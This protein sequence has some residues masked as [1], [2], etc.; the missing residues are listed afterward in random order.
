MRDDRLVLWR[1]LLHHVRHPVGGSR[2][3]QTTSHPMRAEL[4]STEQLRDHFRGLAGWH[5]LEDRSWR[6]DPLLRRLDDNAEVLGDA[7]RMLAEAASAK[8]RLAPA[9][10]WLLDNNYLI[11]E[12]VRTARRHLPRS[13][14]RLLPKLGNGPLAG[15]ARTYSL[16]YELILHVDARVD[17]ASLRESIAAYQE[18]APLR[19]GEL[20]SVPIMLRL[21]LIENLRRVAMRVSRG[22][23][24]T[25]LALEWSRRLVELAEHRPT[26]LVVGLADLSRSMS[27]LPT[28][29]VT[30]LSRRIR[31]SHHGMGLV[32][33]WLEQRLGEHGASIE[34]LESAENRAQ[35]ADRV[36]VGNSISSMRTLGAMDWRE[37]VEQMSVAERCLRQDPAGVYPGCAFQTRDQ[38]RHVVESVSRRSKLSEEEVASLAVGLAGRAPPGHLDGRSRHVGWWLIGEGRPELEAA[39]QARRGV[40]RRLADAAYHA[41]LPLYLL[42]VVAPS[43]AGWWWSAERLG[44]AGLAQPWTWLLALA[45]ALVVSQLAIT[46]LNWWC[47]IALRPQP[48]PRLELKEGLPASCRT[49]VL[50]PCQLSDAETIDRLLDGLEVRWVGNREA[51]TAMLLLTDFE[52]AQEERLPGDQA[53]VDRVAQGIDALNARWGNPSQPRPFGLLHR[54][55]VRCP[56]EGRWMGWERKRGKI[57]QFL[58]AL[59]DPWQQG[60]PRGFS[61]V[62]AD[63]AWLREVV[64]CLV[65]DADTRLPMESV[66]SLAA[67]MHHPL[68]RPLVGPTRVVERGHGLLQPRVG[69]T[70]TS[71]RSS[72]YAMMQAVEPGLD[73]YTRTVSDIYQDLFDEG[74]FVGKGIFEVSTFLTT[75]EGRMPE[76]RIL[77]HDLLEGSYVRAGLI[78]DIELFE[79]TPSA[80]LGD[81]SRRHRWVRGDW[82]AAAWL[83]RRVPGET[84]RERNPLHLLAQWKLLDN[85]RR[86]LVPAA[87]VAA[88]VLGWCLGRSDCLLLVAA[89]W[90]VPSA[91]MLIRSL[92]RRPEAMPLDQHLRFWL[93]SLLR[94]A[95]QI[96][97]AAV[98]ALH[99]AVFQLDAILR[100][101]WR[102]LRRRRL[103]EWKTAAAAERESLGLAGTV[104][105][106]APTLL[107][108]LLLVLLLELARPSAL[109]PA[110]PL[111][112]LWLASPVL[113]WWLARPPER[114]SSMQV[115]EADR[116]WLR[117][118]ARRTWRWF[119][120]F[121]CEEHNFLAP[122]NFQEHPVAVVA[123]R[124]SPTNIGLGL[125]CQLAA[126]DFGWIGGT[127][128]LAQLERSLGSLERLER[129]HGHLLN[130]YDTRTLKPLAPHYVSTV[131]SG[132]CVGSL[133]VLAAG[134]EELPGQL[135][136]DPQRCEGLRDSLQLA[137][138]AAG[139][140][141]ARFQSSVA[142]LDGERPTSLPAWARWIRLAQDDQRR[143]RQRLPGD[144]AQWWCGAAVRQLQEL[145][146][147]LEALA[148]WLELPPPPEGAATRPLT[149]LLEGIGLPTLDD[150]IALPQ[151][152]AGHLASLRAI[153]ALA[154]WAGS[155]ER[156]LGKGAEQAGLLAAKAQELA[157]RMRE[158]AQA[159]F[160]VL[161]DKQR[162]LFYHRLQHHRPPLR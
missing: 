130:W 8:R 86:S 147:E 133:L 120:T 158:M 19:L 148:P 58:R 80:Y 150:I 128:L 132:N 157:G 68:N 77:S 66:R 139:E 43:L 17:A 100:A 35:A 7:Y 151:R 112:L 63:E 33:S 51:E 29:F 40:L 57:L 41:G 84:A 12:Q 46:L 1:S 137:S 117:L 92:L 75:L 156:A 101:A 125:L 159:D 45:P 87:A 109:V 30:D 49:A 76:G 99:E 134:L 54:D 26:E 21:A 65:V 131:D 85:L 44:A 5:V 70:L 27:S 138:E 64:Y 153:P 126:R 4:L 152:L 145:K 72:H 20:W 38:Y 31:G 3:E 50:V 135:A 37:F 146:E 48:L 116:R 74:S 121:A 94:H 104:R 36:S 25:D 98:T 79:D 10:E 42:G 67:A 102:L 60:L 82:Q 127:T 34:Q 78:S 119:E 144:E 18:I 91:A 114:A 73:A 149:Q 160:R 123:G 103:L 106:M 16:A 39:A 155:L 6:T 122:D 11:E 69:I 24:E 61:L 59:R 89:L 55:R 32:L 23:E 162:N 141:Q 161:Y 90:V 52:D 110:A 2:P 136:L 97:F 28:G 93:H 88:L 142:R 115:T 53:L 129:H 96:A 56:R 113:A 62:R 107:I 15:Y 14:H 111:L 13:Y 108:C 71:A 154:G 83:L 143:V 81:C 9:A 118:R 47:S 124:T 105:A 95:G 140:D 22:R